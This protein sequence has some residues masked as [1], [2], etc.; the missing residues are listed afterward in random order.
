ME[1]CVVALMV[2]VYFRCAT[3]D[4]MLIQQ[5]KFCWMSHRSGVAH[6]K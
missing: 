3:P 4:L 6:L 2:T 1:R 5:N